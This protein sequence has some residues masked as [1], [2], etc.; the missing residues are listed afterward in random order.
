MINP[1]IAFYV[2][3]S[4]GRLS[5]ILSLNDSDL[6]SQIKLVFSDDS[7]NAFLKS[8]LDKFA[9]PFICKDFSEIE[10]PNKSLKLSD[11]ILSYLNLHD[12]DYC[13]CFGDH[14]LKGDLVDVYRNR[15][16]NFHPSLLP[17]FPG[18]KAIDQA[19][20]A[21][22]CVLGNTAHFIDEGIDTGPIIMQSVTSVAVFNELGYEGILDQ[23]IPMLFTILSSIK[24]NELKIVNNVV[25]IENGVYSRTSFFP[26]TK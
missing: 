5:K 12:I 21:G 16:I 18:R 1:R 2:S 13:F 24:K 8:D 14:I 6:M 25:Y 20:Q 9:I 3:G 7:R 17:S 15:I 23:Q 4:A 11:N 10:G 26:E 19:I 22:A